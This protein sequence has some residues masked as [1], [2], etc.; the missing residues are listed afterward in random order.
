MTEYEVIDLINSTQEAGI[1]ASMAFV[2]I[3]SAYV[4]GMHMLADKL[5]PL[6]LNLLVLV[7]SLYIIS[8]IMFFYG[9][10]SRMLPL[11]A[12]YQAIHGEDHTIGEVAYFET[13]ILIGIWVLCLFYTWHVRH[14]NSQSHD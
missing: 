13:A 3:S 1:A 12:D 7:Y 10:S 9:A 5:P 8:P 4:I 14:K 11:L 2:T 6:Y